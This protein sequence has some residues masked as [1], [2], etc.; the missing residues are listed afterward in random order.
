MAKWKEPTT[1]VAV[2]GVDPRAR[3][4]EIRAEVK[5]FLKGDTL[6]L[7][8]L[9][10]LPNNME[11]A[12]RVII[13]TQDLLEIERDKHRKATLHICEL[14]AIL[15]GMSQNELDAMAMIGQ[16]DR[17]IHELQQL[18]G[19]H[20]QEIVAT[21]REA[22]HMRHQRDAVL[23]TMSLQANMKAP[24]PVTMSV[25]VDMGSSNAAEPARRRGPT[26]FE[27]LLKGL[28]YN[29]GTVTGRLG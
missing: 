7:A 26:T 22:Q 29:G 9:G 18:N 24:E 21:R 15:E 8:H 2:T 11:D 5:A 16:R 19:H 4:K 14:V 10:D 20:E 25:G 17:Q 13:A 3:M 27:E 6:G 23:T 28:A 12:R 1:Q